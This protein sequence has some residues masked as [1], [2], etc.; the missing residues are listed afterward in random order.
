MAWLP[1][2]KLKKMRG[3]SETRTGRGG[4]DQKQKQRKNRGKTAKRN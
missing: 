3:Q 2:Q 4:K 1:F